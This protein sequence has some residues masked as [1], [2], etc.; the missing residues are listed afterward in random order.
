M[1]P[2]RDAGLLHLEAYSTQRCCRPKF[3]VSCKSSCNNGKHSRGSS[4]P[5][6]GQATLLLSGHLDAL[7]YMTVGQIP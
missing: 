2:E 3:M 5:C 4:E 7:H 6:N 1:T